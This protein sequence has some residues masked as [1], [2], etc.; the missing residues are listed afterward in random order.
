MRTDIEK[1]YKSRLFS[2]QQR[3][4]WTTLLS[5]ENSK[6]KPKERAVTWPL[7][8]IISNKSR[9]REK[10]KLQGSDG[11][12]LGFLGNRPE[13]VPPDVDDMVRSQV[14]PLREVIKNVPIISKCMSFVTVS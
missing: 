14:A 3:A 7:Q 6:W 11:D 13:G 5:D 4:E 8:N 12:G 1:Y 2:E 9:L 10:Q